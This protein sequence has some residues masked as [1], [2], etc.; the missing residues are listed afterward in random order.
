MLTS[1][2]N[3]ESFSLEARNVLESLEC[4]PEESSF[5]VQERANLS[6]VSGL[7]TLFLL[8]NITTWPCFV[9]CIL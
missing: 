3:S 2:E 9:P 4:H 8:L 1:L 6:I 7:H 5:D